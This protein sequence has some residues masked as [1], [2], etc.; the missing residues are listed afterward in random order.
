[1][2]HLEFPLQPRN[3]DLDA[4]DVFPQQIHVRL[5]RIAHLPFFRP[6]A[7]DETHDIGFGVVREIVELSLQEFARLGRLR[8]KVYRRDAV[9][10]DGRVIPRRHH[11]ARARL[12]LR[13]ELGCHVVVRRPVEDDGHFLCEFAVRRRTRLCRFRQ[14]FGM[15]IRLGHVPTQYAEFSFTGCVL[16]VEHPGNMCALDGRE[17]RRLDRADDETKWILLD[18]LSQGWDVGFSVNCAKIHVGGGTDRGFVYTLNMDT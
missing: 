2:T 12:G 10:L 8:V 6:I 11:F 13:V 7:T 15:W 17:I 14:C 16:D 3:L 9:C 4:D 5:R 1:M 18:E